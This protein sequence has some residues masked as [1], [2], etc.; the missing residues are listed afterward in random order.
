MTILG[1]TDWCVPSR[2]LE[3]RILAVSD[4]CHGIACSSIE[5]DA[6]LGVSTKIRA[7]RGAV[8]TESGLGARSPIMVMELVVR[9]WVIEADRESLDFVLDGIDVTAS[10]GIEDIA[11]RQGNTRGS[12]VVIGTT[13]ILARFAN[14]VDFRRHVVGISSA[15]VTE[16]LISGVRGGE[17]VISVVLNVS[18]VSVPLDHP[19]F[20]AGDVE[21]E[22]RVGAV[23]GQVVGL[24]ANVDISIIRGL[25]AGDAELSSV[26]AIGISSVV[27][28]IDG[29]GGRIVAWAGNV[30]SCALHCLTGVASEVIDLFSVGV[31]IIIGCRVAGVVEE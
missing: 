4:C 6:F 10:E 22:G 28:L 11:T 9:G 29:F 2:A 8:K 1:Q 19:L 23:T 5:I 18:H 17:V 27:C 3:V 14:E 12:V 26:F 20:I 7:N 15:D 31:V 25:R 13:V 24:H 21:S 30:S 16:N